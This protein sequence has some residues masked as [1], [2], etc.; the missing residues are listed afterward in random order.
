V[1]VSQT[2]G[3]E[4]RHTTRESRATIGISSGLGLKLQEEWPRP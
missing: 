3:M 2:A 4:E 1:T